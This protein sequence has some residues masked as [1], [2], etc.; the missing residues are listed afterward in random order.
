[1]IGTRGTRA[2]AAAAERRVAR[3]AKGEGENPGKG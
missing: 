1:M 3:E 2:A